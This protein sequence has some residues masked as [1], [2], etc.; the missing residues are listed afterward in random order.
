MYATDITGDGITDL[1]V[2]DDHRIYIFKGSDSLGYYP[3]TKSRAFYSIPNPRVLDNSNTYINVDEFGRYMHAC[4]DLT[5]SGIPYLMVSGD[6]ATSNISLQANAFFYA[7]G[8]AL[9][10]LFDA[11]VSIQNGQQHFSMDT[12]HSIDQS[13][14]S[15]VLLLDGSDY[16]DNVEDLDLLLYKDADRIPYK[17]NPQMAVVESHLISGNSLSILEGN[18]YI[19]LATDVMTNARA[20]VSIYNV[21]GQQIFTK[22]EELSPGQNIIYCQTIGWPSGT[23]VAVVRMNDEALTKTFIIE[24]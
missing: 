9:D 12:L 17:T 14:R 23:Y 2:T 8:K 10:T 22:E 13:G 15:A 24:H 4:G 19:K 5:G 11:V 20:Q 7:G 18:N 21:L 16:W 1:L 3:L 6:P